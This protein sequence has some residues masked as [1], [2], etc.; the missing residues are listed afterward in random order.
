VLEAKGDTTASVPKISSSDSG[1]ADEI[2]WS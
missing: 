1:S 2:G